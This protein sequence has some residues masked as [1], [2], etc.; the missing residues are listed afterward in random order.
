MKIINSV[1]EYLEHLNNIKQT[2]NLTYTVSSFTFF[3]G[4]ANASWKISPSL[5]RQGLFES[6]NLLLTEIRHICPTEIPENR[7]EALVKMQHYGMPTRLLDTTTNPL[8]ALYFACE[9]NTEKENDGAVYI[10]PN[11]PVSWSTDPLIELVMDF[12]FDYYP[13]KVWLDQMLNHSK[14]K[15]SNV[16]HRLMPDN[17]DSL[18]HYLTIPAFAVMPAKTNDRIEVSAPN[19]HVET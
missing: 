4:Q 15:Y 14:K 18:L 8:V 10:F 13:E 19:K 17:I 5:Y 6:E 1:S 9:S 16:I 7:F 3:R 2:R 11:L 12:V